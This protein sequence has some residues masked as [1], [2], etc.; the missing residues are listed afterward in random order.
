MFVSTPDLNFSLQSIE[1]DEGVKKDIFN[2]CDNIIT[3]TK[4]W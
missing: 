2:L 1:R 4:G 3:M